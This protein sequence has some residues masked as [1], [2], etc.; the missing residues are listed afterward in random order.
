MAQQF[1]QSQDLQD[2]DEKR[3][4][5]LGVQTSVPPLHDGEMMEAADEVS[6]ETCIPASKASLTDQKTWEIVKIEAKS[7]ASLRT[8]S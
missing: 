4:G 2:P 1:S 3:S 8:R 6:Q 5:V 7:T